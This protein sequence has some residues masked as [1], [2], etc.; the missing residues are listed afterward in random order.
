MPLPRI[1]QPSA[2]CHAGVHCLLT[3]IRVCCRQ[4]VARTADGRRFLSYTRPWAAVMEFL[5]PSRPTCLNCWPVRF[6]T[7]ACMLTN[8]IPLLSARPVVCVTLSRTTS[9]FYCPNRQNVSS[10]TAARLRPHNLL[11][12]SESNRHISP[13]RFTLPGH[14]LHA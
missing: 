2:T 5:C 14:S 13:A 6:A 12:R 4:S 11:H 9:L 7:A 3:D 10:R 8:T 1:S